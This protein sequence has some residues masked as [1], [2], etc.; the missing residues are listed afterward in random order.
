[1]DWDFKRGLWLGLFSPAPVLPISWWWEYF[2]HRGTTKYIG[3][4]RSVLDQMLAAGN[5][6]FSEI[7]CQWTG[8]PVN[9]LSVKCG[10]TLF[11][12][13][14]NTNS[15]QITGNL[16]LPP[17]A[18]NLWQ[19][20]AYDPEKDTTHALPAGLAATNITVPPMDC[21]ILIA[22]PRN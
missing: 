14:E 7:K 5:G 13:L 15:F 16:S 21:L 4:V 11:T 19:I 12:L 1:M 3:H 20:E 10:S 6:T 9:T 18:I 8:P 2:D 22:N 17:G